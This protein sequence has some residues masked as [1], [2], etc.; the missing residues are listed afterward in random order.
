MYDG[1]CVFLF[2]VGGGFVECDLDW[3]VLL[4]FGV[5]LYF[6]GVYLVVNWGKVFVWFE[7]VYL[8]IYLFGRVFLGFCF[9][10][11]LGGDIGRWV[12]CLICFDLVFYGYLNLV[13]G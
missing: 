11:F 13:Y 4:G 2:Y 9:L 10:W 12:Y 5:L 1:V 3:Y 7:W 6:L 8:D